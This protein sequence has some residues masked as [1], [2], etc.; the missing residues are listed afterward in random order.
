MVRLPLKG[1]G[2]TGCQE[3]H[4]VQQKQTQS[5]VCEEEWPQALQ[6]AVAGAQLWRLASEG[7][8]W[9]QDG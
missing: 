8:G 3:H 5:S 2:E 9:H 6:W 4:D 1:A 7:P